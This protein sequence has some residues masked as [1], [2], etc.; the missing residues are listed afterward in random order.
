MSKTR[1]F[2]SCEHALVALELFSPDQERG[3]LALGLRVPCLVLALLDE[4]LNAF[5]FHLQ[6]VHLRWLHHAVTES[7]ERSFTRPGLKDEGDAGPVER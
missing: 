4:L 2:H 6:L 1:D 3:L 5:P 7:G